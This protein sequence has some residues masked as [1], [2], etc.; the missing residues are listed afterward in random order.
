MTS[1]L[2]WTR[3]GIVAKAGPII[4][5]IPDTGASRPLTV[6]AKIT[7]SQFEYAETVKAQAA[8]IKDGVVISAPDALE[9]AMEC[10][11]EPVPEG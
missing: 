1:K 9:M 4:S 7:S 2:I 10:D 8:R 6:S 11:I 5:V 3:T